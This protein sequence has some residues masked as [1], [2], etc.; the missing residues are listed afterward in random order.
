LG[1]QL[2]AVV[3]AD[4]HQLVLVTLVVQVVVRE[5]DW[6]GL[7]QQVRALV[8]AVPTPQT[9]FLA[10]LLVAVAVLVKLVVLY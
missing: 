4:L 9:V 6:E 8:G 5:R 10:L 3:L 2:L 7:I 1:L